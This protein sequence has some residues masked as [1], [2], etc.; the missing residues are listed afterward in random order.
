MSLSLLIC[1]NRIAENGVSHGKYKVCIEEETLNF[2][3]KSVNKEAKC[4]L[5]GGKTIFILLMF[6]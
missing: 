6:M 5:F 1:M 4:L 3:G 2:T